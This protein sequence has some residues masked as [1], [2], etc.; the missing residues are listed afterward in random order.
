MDPRY[1]PVCVGVKTRLEGPSSSWSV[2]AFDRGVPKAVAVLCWRPIHHVLEFAQLYRLLEK[3]RETAPRAELHAWLLSALRDWDVLRSLPL[4]GLDVLPDDGDR[5]AWNALAE[6]IQEKGW[7]CVTLD[8][9]EEAANRLEGRQIK[10]IQGGSFSFEGPA[11]EGPNCAKAT[12]RFY[13]ALCRDAPRWVGGPMPV[14]MRNDSARFL[15]HQSRFRVGNSL[16]LTPLL[17]S[18]HD[19]FPAAQVTVT[20]SPAAASAL[21][22]NPNCSEF[23]EYDP[24]GGQVERDRVAGLLRQRTFDAAIFALVRRPKSRWLA[25]AAATMQ[26]PVRVNLEYIDAP[27]DGTQAPDLFTHEGWFHWS[28]ISSARFLLHGLHPFLA[29]RDTWRPRD[30]ESC[31]VDFP[32]EPACKQQAGQFLESEGIGDAPFAVLAPG[33]WSSDRWPPGNFA[34]LAMELWDRYRCHAVIHIGPDEEPIREQISAS[35]RRIRPAAEPDQRVVISRNPLGV[36]AALLKRAAILVSNDSAPIHLA[37]TV[38]LP[39]LYFAHHEKL[40]HSHP[41]CES[42][43]A[44]YDA[45]ANRPAGISVESS[46]NV[47]LEMI[48]QGVVKLNERS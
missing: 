46:R 35:L 43:W 8:A 6:H 13:G 5:F 39:A 41:A 37:E 40:T 19:F 10:C 44:L 11:G 25:E 21:R 36:L 30:S 12:Q 47:L 22:H 18:I 34:A 38:N 15:I 33:G 17:R 7:A 45:S 23:L 27:S 16:W 31:R 24:A 2:P 26:V 3:L 9:S 20:G 29:G 32:I 48:R 4:D 28:N 42:H 1:P 14:A